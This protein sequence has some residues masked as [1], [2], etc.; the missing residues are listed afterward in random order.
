VPHRIGG[1][2]AFRAIALATAVS[3]TA[4][5]GG[6]PMCLS[7]LAQAVTHCAMHLDGHHPGAHTAA[8]PSLQLV[9]PDTEQPC[10]PDASGTGCAAG[11]AC[12]AAA[13]A[14][15]ALADL[16]VAVRSVSRRTAPA[17]AAA[18]LSYL[19][20]PPAPPPQA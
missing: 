4:T 2:L 14:V 16:P 9:S 11:S 7:A 17:S 20:P 1:C 13:P 8:S 3:L 5:S 12:P 15:A 6:L 19:T 18:L 10:H